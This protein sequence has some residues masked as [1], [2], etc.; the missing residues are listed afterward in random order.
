[1]AIA[2]AGLTVQVIQVVAKSRL[3]EKIQ[4][5]VV[6]SLVSAVSD[7]G[8]DTISERI[9][10]FRSD[11]K[12]RKEVQVA[13]EQA[14]K[15]WAE[16]CPDRELVA[17]VAKNT[18]FADLPSVREAVLW[19]AQ[20][21]FDQLPKATILEKFSEVLPARFEHERV[22][23]GIGEFLEILGEEFA[24]VSGLRETQLLLVEIKNLRA[25]QKTAENTA[26]IPN[27]EVILERLEKGPTPTEQTLN[28]YLKWVMD[29]H[30][31][32]DPRGTMQTVRQVQVKLNEVY[33]SLLAEEELPLGAVDRRIYEYEV[34]SLLEREDLSYEEKED[35]KENLLAKILEKVEPTEVTREPRALTELVQNHAKLVI[36]GDPGVGKSTLL[37]YLAYQQAS[38][39]RS[40]MGEGTQLDEARMPLYLRIAN[41]AEHGKGRSLDE[42]LPHHV[43]GEIRDGNTLSRLVKDWLEAGQCLVLL[44][45]LDEVIEPA[46][47]SEIAGEINSFLRKHEDAGN[48]FV[49]TS[50]VAGYRSAPLA[51]D[52]PHFR[53]QDMNENQIDCFLT[54]WCNAVERFQTPDLPVSM[55]SQKAQNEIDGIKKSIAENPGVRRLATNP[56]LLRTLALI[57]R[58]G[59]RLPA[60]RID[61]YRLAADTLIR[62]W[63][64][65]RGIPE[66]VLVQEA[67][68]TQLLAELAAWMH[69]EK[70]AGIATLGEVRRCLTEV[71]GRLDNKE[72]DHPEIL[73]AT[74]DFISRIRQHTGLFV[75]RAPNRYGFMHLTFEEYFAARYLV[76]KPRQAARRIRCRLHNPRW[77]EPILLAIGY[78]GAEFPDDVD[79][80]VEEAILGKRLGGSSLYEEILHRDLLFAVRVMGDQDLGSKLRKRLVKEFADVWC[81]EQVGAAK[82][83]FLS[84]EMEKV[85][86]D[87]K[88]SKAEIALEEQFIK[89]IQSP[90]TSVR[91][92]SVQALANTTCRSEVTSI[93]I[94]LLRD[95]EAIVRRRAASALEKTIEQAEVTSALLDALQ[96]ENMGVHN[97]TA[98]ILHNAN[99]QAVLIPALLKAIQHEKPIVRRNA[100]HTLQFAV[101]QAEVTIALLKALQ[102]EDPD[103]RSS[104]AYTLKGG[105]GQE[106]VTFAL[107]KALQDEHSDVRRSA[108]S[109]LQSAAEQE[110]VTK[111]LLIAL[112][113]EDPD[114]RR[115]AAYAL[116]GVA[117]QE[118]VTKALLNTLQD[119]N[120]DVCLY[121]LQ[122]VLKKINVTALLLK[123]IQLEEPIVRRN[124]AY[125]LQ[126]VVRQA[127]V[128]EALLITLQDE[129]PD[130]R[131]Y[132]AHSLKGAAGEEE[133][134]LALIKALQDKHSDVRRRA[135][136]ALQN[137]TGQAEVTKALLNALQDEDPEVRRCAASSLNNLTFHSDSVSEIVSQMEV[138]NRVM[139][140]DELSEPRIETIKGQNMWLAGCDYLYQILRSYAS[141]PCRKKM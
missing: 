6:D 13:L 21:P 15:R 25:N 104:A 70:P 36:L 28:D 45:G 83:V 113:D 80:L 137:A 7:S 119:K 11:G 132:T 1:M 16:I 126:F 89:K 129:D 90:D 19:L 131:S 20:H 94:N 53:V 57:H 135:A 112:Q 111:A 114:V 46:Q 43:C 32:L 121:A 92:R 52:I 141:G 105:T 84:E 102:D 22:T 100:S 138:I 41:Y 69:E 33:V 12:L 122:N 73:K 86:H 98:Y 81:D 101:E 85:L 55:T 67:E 96:D 130:V 44:D 34:K 18:T 51:G 17:A 139:R 140:E 49:V 10:Q 39:L 118:E 72:P 76:A 24:L 128:T 38:M 127:E 77:A 27:I 37:R 2:A 125:T 88:G 60:R 64:L 134:A 54:Q 109:A 93:L 29:Q 23:R 99:K 56:L 65:E 120:A 40:R 66:R 58:T 95:E 63:E 14:A 116:E 97:V 75:E 79:E 30:R 50:R 62:D 87:I 110:E 26:R 108:A 78:Y 91:Y 107:I 42:F 31:Y 133:V 103:V 82:F 68:A 9:K 106:E 4:D 123:A 3:A 71:K 35:L 47:R 117:G 8:K 136:Y 48:R 61:L 115:N 59:S 5:C 124:A 74:D